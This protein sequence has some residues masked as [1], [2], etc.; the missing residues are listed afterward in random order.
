MTGD[1]KV[2]KRDSGEE[3]R[4]PDSTVIGLLTTAPPIPLLLNIWVPSLIYVVSRGKLGKQ[5]SIVY[6]DFKISV[7]KNSSVVLVVRFHLCPVGFSVRLAIRSLH[8]QGY[9][10]G[11]N[12]Y[13]YHCDIVI[14]IRVCLSPNNGCIREFFKFFLVESLIDAFGFYFCSATWWWAS[15]PIAFTGLLVKALHRSSDKIR[16]KRTVATRF[17]VLQQYTI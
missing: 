16:R 13:D 10:T 8:Q 5:R 3:I 6:I 1:V 17:L 2:M 15:C 14:V 4:T 7:L 11:D 9:L 12:D